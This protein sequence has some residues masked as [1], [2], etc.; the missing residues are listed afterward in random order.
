MPEL[1]LGLDVGT[2]SLGAGVFSPA[3]KLLAWSSRRLSTRSPGPARLDQD[4]A[5]IWRAALAAIRADLAAIGVTSQRTSI[6]VWD[7]RTSQALTPLVLWSDLS[8]AARAAELRD[9]GFF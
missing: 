4:A 3:G 6:V 1:L 2:T 7:R 5:A 8:G 9:R